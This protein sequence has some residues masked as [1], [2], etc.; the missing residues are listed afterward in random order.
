MT[1][2]EARENQTPSSA[3]VPFCRQVRS[4]IAPCLLPPPSPLPE[5]SLASTGESTRAVWGP[6]DVAVHVRLGDILHGYHAAYRPLP[7]S[8]YRWVPVVG[9]SHTRATAPSS[10]PSLSPQ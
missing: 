6:H 5:P 3:A 2:G 1:G 4:W 10:T 8:F 9:A 7:M